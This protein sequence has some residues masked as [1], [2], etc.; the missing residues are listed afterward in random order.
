MKNHSDRRD[1][2]LAE[3]ISAFLDGELDPATE[4]E[5]EKQ[6]FRDIQARRLFRGMVD[7]DTAVKAAFAAVD[8]TPSD[9][10]LA[11]IDSGFNARR[12]RDAFAPMLLRNLAR[13]AAI[14]VV[15]AGT[16]ALTA[17]YMSRQMD[18]A[19]AKL[20]ASAETDRRLID[21]AVRQ[22]LETQTSGKVVSLAEYGGPE[23]TLKPTRT[24]RSV[25]GHWCRDYVRTIRLD[26]R[27]LDIHGVA[28]RTPEGEW[29]TVKAEPASADPADGV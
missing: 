23:G 27:S 22:V 21:N 6:L 29:V 19:L 17:T 7:D 26:R 5:L 18:Q 9:A 3:N 15:I 20:A 28:C 14:F 1:G 24:Y 25:S 10:L 12:R 16:A 11:T 8:T 4:S 2:Q 13:A